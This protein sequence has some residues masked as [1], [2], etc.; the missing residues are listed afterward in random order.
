[1]RIATF[2]I[3]SG[4]ALDRETTDPSLLAQ[5]LKT[6]DADVIG[7]QEVDRSQQRS[8]GVDQAALAAES[9]GAAHW[10]FVPALVGTPGHI[11]RRGRP[12][13]DE[14][15]GCGGHN[16]AM[17]GVAL[18]SRYPV[19]SWHVLRL[20][21]VPVR[22]PVLLRD[23]RGR[24]RFVWVDDEPRAAVAGV[25]DTPAGTM[26]IAT[27]HLTFVP[28]W[29]LGQLRAVT[30]WLGSLPGPHILTGDLN[31][32]SPLPRFACR[33]WRSLAAAATWTADTPRAQLDHLLA[34]GEGLPAVGGS[35]APRLQ[36]S[37]HRALLVD[38]LIG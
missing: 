16:P 33:R 24:R 19:R 38:L 11:W 28:L 17:Y 5:A 3:F 34:R 9:M 14:V 20:P 10:K 26:T 12:A 22:A 7:L 8:G 25:V 29:S 4:R 18:V 13:D 30:R 6:L 32:P 1:M 37:D 15:D 21:R 31:M 2:N 35:D 23:N 27:T 36:L